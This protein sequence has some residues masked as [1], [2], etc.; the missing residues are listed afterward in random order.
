MNGAKIQNGPE[1]TIGSGRFF[2]L[3]LFSLFGTFLGLEYSAL[4][5]AVALTDVYVF[6]W[7][8]ADVLR[9]V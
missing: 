2:D 9:Q 4:D 5:S 3:C 1:I 6:T 7:E 8:T